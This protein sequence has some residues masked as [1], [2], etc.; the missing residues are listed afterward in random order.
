VPSSAVSAYQNAEVW[1]NFIIEEGGFLVNTVANNNNYG[2]TT[3]AGLYEPNATATISATAYSGYK[4]AN[5][6]KDGVEVSTENPYSFTV[7][8]D[9]EWVANFEVHVGIV[10]TRHA[11]SLQVYP[12]PT[13]G[14]LRFAVSGE[15][16]AVCDIE[17]FD[18]YGRKHESTKARR[19][20]NMNGEIV[21]DIAHLP[22]GVYFVRVNTGQGVVTRKVVKM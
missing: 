2:Y 13:A 18:V 3:G 11:L 1:K 10:E 12:N 19:H 21:I 22:A 14:E 17:I 6:S 8:E 20:E 15:R 5:W 7:T 16:Y 4:F 9:G